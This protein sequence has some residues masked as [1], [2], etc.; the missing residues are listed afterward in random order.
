LV[1]YYWQYLSG[2]TPG[3]T[4]TRSLWRK[5]PAAETKILEVFKDL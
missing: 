5:A 4:T 1:Q 2:Q 3:S